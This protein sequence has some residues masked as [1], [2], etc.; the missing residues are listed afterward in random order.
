MGYYV[1]EMFYAV[2]YYTNWAK[3]AL[4]FSKYIRVLRRVGKGFYCKYCEFKKSCHSLPLSGLYLAT[5]G[6]GEGAAERG[7]VG[8]NHLGKL[9]LG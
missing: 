8:P 1:Q 7:G 4:A 9:A 3:T 2:S 5:D 6:L